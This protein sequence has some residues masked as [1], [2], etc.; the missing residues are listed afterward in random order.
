MLR[1]SPPAVLTGVASAYTSCD[2]QR[3]YS[4]EAPLEYTRKQPRVGSPIA[5]KQA[6]IEP[7]LF[8]PGVF[9][10]G[11]VMWGLNLIELNW[12]VMKRQQSVTRKHAASFF[13]L[14][15]HT[16]THIQ[17]QNKLYGRACQPCHCRPSSFLITG[18]F[19]RLH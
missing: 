4:G 2:W 16:H 18:A 9:L 11:E 7:P 17:I 5:R 3:S 6:R 13:F 12:W 8:Y 15:T 10:P 19:R 14:T 1:D